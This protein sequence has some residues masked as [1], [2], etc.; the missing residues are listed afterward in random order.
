MSL[1]PLES[2]LDH[3]TARVTQAVDHLRIASTAPLEEGWITCDT[4]IHDP[5]RLRD[6]IRSTAAGRGTDVDSV[7]AS[8][9]VQ[10]YAYRVGSAALA[11]YALGL[12][13]PGVRPPATA[14]RINRHRPAAVAVLDHEVAA[15]SVAQLAQELLGGHMA[16]LI[17]SVTAT[18][19]VGRRLL[20]GNTAASIATLFR[21]IDGAPGADRI[22]VQRRAVE[23]FEAATP[24][25]RDLGDFTT[26][27]AAGRTGWY[28][29]RAN[30]CLWYQC[31]G[32][33][34]CDDCSLH[35]PDELVAIRNAQLQG[36]S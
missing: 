3:I 8:L 26:L 25:L 15:R 2:D 12:P 10:G 27:E 36:A 35:S 14:I 4:L 7:A 29:N 6:L 31:S 28:W 20:W 23:F 17:A 11:P 5:S 9:F 30:C 24:W 19:T 34:R 33:S 32:G 18:V 1:L 22:A 21:A 13:G 16:P